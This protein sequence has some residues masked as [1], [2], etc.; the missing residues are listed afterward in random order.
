MA[1][2]VW[3]HFLGVTGPVYLGVTDPHLYYGSLL[4]EAIVV[5]MRGRLLRV[6]DPLHQK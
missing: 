5:Y 2:Q 4:P 6:C 3:G 1:D